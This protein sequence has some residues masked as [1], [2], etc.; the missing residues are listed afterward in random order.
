MVFCY[1]FLQNKVARA[2]TSGPELIVGTEIGTEVLELLD[3]I[4]LTKYM[5]FCCVNWKLSP[6]APIQVSP[7]TGP[8]LGY[9]NLLTV[10]CPAIPRQAAKTHYGC[11]SPVACQLW[12]TLPSTLP[13]HKD[14]Y[15]L[16]PAIQLPNW[17]EHCIEC[18]IA[19]YKGCN[20][21]EKLTM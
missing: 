18:A 19:E 12:S 8:S 20:L 16:Q 10:F 7:S 11:Y 17:P 6:G 15:I 9:S 1:V 5:T 14:G 2:L 21:G 3:H 4:P 13:K